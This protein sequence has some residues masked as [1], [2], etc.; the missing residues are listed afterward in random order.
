MIVKIS[1]EKNQVWPSVND[2]LAQ[3]ENDIWDND[4]NGKAFVNLSF[5]LTIAP[6]PEALEK[7]K[8]AMQSV[9]AA[10]AIIVTSAGND[11][12]VRRRMLQ[13]ASP[14]KYL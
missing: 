7:F 9:A 8:D 6:S 4:L 10:D 5:H 13:R 12:K 2:A 14:K 3:V 11:G 1:L